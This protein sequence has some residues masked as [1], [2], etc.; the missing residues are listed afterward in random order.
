MKWP[1]LVDSL[2][3]LE[4]E[5]VPITLFVDE[6]GIVRFVRPQPEDLESFLE[7]TY[8]PPVEASPSYRFPGPNLEQMRR[9]AQ[10]EAP[11][12]MRRVADAL[13]LWGGSDGLDE[14]IQ[15]YQDILERKPEDALTHFRLGVAFRKRYDSS[16]EQAGD[17]ANAVQHWKTALDIDP[18][19][20]IW[21]RRIQQYGPRLDKPYPFYDWI[22]QAREEIKNRGDEPV[23]LAV[24]PGGA[25]FAA[26]A[27]QFSVGE[28]A[29]EPDPN[30]RIYRDDGLIKIETVV[31]PHTDRD[32]SAMGHVIFKP[33]DSRKAHWNNEVEDLR[34][35]VEPPQGWFVER[36]LYRYANPPEAVT[37]EERQIDI[38]L[39]GPENFSGSVTI[40]GYAL[41]F[42]CEDV[43]GT[44]LYRR[45]DFSIRYDGR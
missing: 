22:H 29:E 18:N 45:Q 43:N 33:N 39:N 28:D 44:C 15:L 24:E 7:A 37:Q 35:W 21:R 27:E 17:F 38:E 40:P 11:E 26:P 31:V 4:V 19:Q 10:S 25:E 5:A 34:V 36:K 1:V 42:V 2:N 13:V 30:G 32:S 6:Y 23:F 9:K 14:A 12:D 8:E 41:Y 16:Q 3:L 20:Y